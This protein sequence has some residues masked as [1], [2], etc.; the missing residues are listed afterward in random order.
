MRLANLI[1]LPARVAKPRRAKR[2]R[3][4]FLTPEETFAVLRTARDRDSRTWAMLLLAYRHGLRASEVCG[5]R[6]P[7]LYVPYAGCL[8]FQTI[9]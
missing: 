3:V 5:L 1:E 2:G 8:S 6:V 4:A 9:Y 7:C